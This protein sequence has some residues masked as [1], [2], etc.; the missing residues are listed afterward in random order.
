MTAETGP[1]PAL[2]TDFWRFSV[3]FYGQPGVAAACLALQDRHGLDVNLVLLCLW[4]GEIGHRLTPADLARLKRAVARWNTDVLMPLRAARQALKPGPASLYAAAKT[5][6]LDAERHAQGM[7]LDAL[8][9]QPTMPAT[10]AAAVANL[11]LYLPARA[12]A[13]RSALLTALSADR[14]E[15]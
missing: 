5:L 8:G 3:A 7:L 14:T 2:S 12:G 10:H 13:E 11:D 4:V 6:E 1:P 9:K 15:A